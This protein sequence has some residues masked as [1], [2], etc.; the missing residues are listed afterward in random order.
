MKQIAEHAGGDVWHA[1]MRSSAEPAGAAGTASS[2]SSKP[3]MRSTSGAGGAAGA[4]VAAALAPATGEVSGSVSS[5]MR[6]STFLAFCRTVACAERDARL[7]MA[8][9]SACQHTLLHK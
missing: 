7:L 2:P 4:A 8:P 6:L 1:P 9:G 5:P 3:P